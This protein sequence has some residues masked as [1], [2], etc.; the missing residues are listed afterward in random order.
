MYNDGLLIIRGSEV[1][2]LLSGRELE[3]IQTVRS[4]YEAHRRGSSALPH[5]LFL[6]FPADDRNRIIALP[7]YLGDDFGVA[8]V[9]WVSSFPANTEAGLDRASA[10][11]VLNSVT[12]GRPQMLLEG[13]VINAKR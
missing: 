3:I 1:A 2:S 8:G 5:S 6:R 11:I 4:A 13:S 10:I 9:K 7:A 12:N